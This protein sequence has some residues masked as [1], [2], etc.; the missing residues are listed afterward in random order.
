[1]PHKAPKLPSKE[2]IASLASSDIDLADAQ[3]LPPE[4]YVGADFYE[5]E[6]S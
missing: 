1:M 3:T 2:F 5:F 6:K 4:C